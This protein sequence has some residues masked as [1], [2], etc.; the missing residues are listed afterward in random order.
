MEFAYAFTTDQPFA[1]VER[2]I[3]AAVTAHGFRVLHVHDVQATFAEKGITREPYKIIEVCN[4]R[5]AHQALSASPYIGLMMPCKINLWVEQGKTHVALLKPS[6]LA[7]LFPNADMNTLAQEVE[8]ALR[9]VID[10]V[11]NQQS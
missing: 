1:E 7:T 5:Y 9:S 11:K 2:A 3:H 6:L 10:A 4:V 8:L